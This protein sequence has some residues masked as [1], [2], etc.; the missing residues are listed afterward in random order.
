LFRLPGIRRWQIQRPTS[1]C[2]RPPRWTRGSLAAA[3]SC[4]SWAARTTP[5]PKPSRRRRS[6][7]TATL[8]PLPDCSSSPTEPHLATA[9]GPPGRLNRPRSAPGWLWRLRFGV[10]PIFR[11]GHGDSCTLPA[12]VTGVR[13]GSA[14]S[15][16]GQERL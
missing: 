13:A 8:P 7:S 5:C 2:T 4:W 16:A 15:R 1:R 12:W 6:S 9:S 14:V 10:W 3:R 11:G